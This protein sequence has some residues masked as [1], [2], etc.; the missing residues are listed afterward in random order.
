MESRK[1]ENNQQDSEE[2]LH[3]FTQSVLYIKPKTTTIKR[4]YIFVK[5]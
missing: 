2:I 5:K 3:T 1:T 4:D